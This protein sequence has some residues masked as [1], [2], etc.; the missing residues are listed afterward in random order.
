M[1][2]YNL[3]GPATPFFGDDL[4]NPLAGIK[5]PDLSTLAG[6]A[7]QTPATPPIAPPQEQPVADPG[8]LARAFGGDRGYGT[9]ADTQRMAVLTSF[10]DAAGPAAFQAGLTGNKWMGLAQ[11]LSG[12]RKGYEQ[13]LQQDYER[14]R[15]EEK[16]KL[17]AETNRAQLTHYTGQEKRAAETHEQ[18]MQR[19]RQRKVGYARIA[20]QASQLGID[21]TYTDQLGS[22]IES[23]NYDAADELVSEIYSMLPERQKVRAD[24]YLREAGIKAQAEIEADK[25]KQQAGYG[26]IVETQSE[27]AHRNATLAETRRYHDAS[28]ANQQR[29]DAN[30][31]GESLDDI[32]DRIWQREKALLEA[33]A[34]V[35]ADKITPADAHRQALEAEL[36]APPFQFEVLAKKRPG[37]LEDAWRLRMA[38]VPWSKIAEDF[39]RFVGAK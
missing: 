13:R 23:G 2:G 30:R 39:Y 34:G 26:P 12:S 9:P 24:A 22:Y 16:D 5:L 14:R 3:F 32:K 18:T 4:M 33:N 35:G 21:K 31:G 7:A 6:V 29:D 37:A 19:E 1:S 27:A 28:I 17:E 38:G 36:G 15:Q 20:Q 8:F 11:A 25:A 10:L